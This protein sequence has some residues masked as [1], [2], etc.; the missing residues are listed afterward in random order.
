MK[1]R[2]GEGL[3]SIVV[4]PPGPASGKLAQRLAEVESR[5]VTCMTPLPPVFWDEARGANVRDVDGNTYVDLTGGFGVAASGHSH[6]RVVEAV[7]RQAE[8]LGHNLGD[9]HPSEVKVMLLERLAEVTP[10][11]LGV[12]I[13]GSAGAE[14]VEAALKTAVLSTGR[15]GI[16]AFTGAYHGLTYGALSLCWRSHFRRHFTGQLFNG[17]HFAPY[18]A[19]GPG[20]DSDVAAASLRELERIHDAVSTTEPVGAIIVE[21][22]QGRAGIR[23]PAP[24]FL[25]GLKRFCEAH[26]I[27]LILDE[28]YTGFGRTGRWFACEHEAIVPDILLAGKAM[29]GMLPVSAAIGTPEIMAAW[30]PSQ[31]EAI[32]TSTFLGNPVACAAALAQIQVIQDDSLVSRAA[33]LG[34]TLRQRVLDWTYP[35]VGE[36][37]GIGL[38]QG[39]EL[40]DPETG[41]PATAQAGMVVSRALEQGV[42]VLAEGSDG[43]IIGLTPPLVIT[44]EQLSH[45]MDVLELIIADLV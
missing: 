33:E 20:S 22:I 23:V 43:N 32:H 44:E 42:L 35:I 36:R 28:I 19:A 31:G 37:R 24:G 10:G 4:K 13:L 41:E 18:P 38:F 25:T 29:S 27:V 16:I 8:R 11:N 5:N 12:S 1:E 26:G 9:V 21:P 40:V 34:R 17:V 7:S 6:P 2:F 14:A 3:P 30:P 15:T 45:A 39:L